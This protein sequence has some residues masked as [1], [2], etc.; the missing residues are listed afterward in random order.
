MPT[1]SNRPGK[2]RSLRAAAAR[3]LDRV[4]HKHRSLDQVLSAAGA[5]LR[6]EDAPL[7]R[8][9][10]TGAIRHFYSLQA[11]VTGALHRPLKDR[12]SVVFCLLLLG[13]YQL[14]HTR[15]PDHAAINET[16]SA[17]NEL[18]RP[19]ARALVNGVLRAV[20]RQPPTPSGDAQITFDHP[21]WLLERLQQDYPQRWQDIA[22]ANNTR[23]PLAL[24]VNLARVTRGD[25]LAL[26][27][28]QGHS[29][30][31]GTSAETILMTSPVARSV[32]P[33]YTDGWVSIQDEG[34]QL[35]APLLAPSAGQRVLDACAA[36]GG[37]ALHLAG[38]AECIDLTALEIDEQRLETLR[39]ES[40][41]LGMTLTL[42]A[43][44]ATQRDWWDGRPFDRILIDAPC[45]G[46][47]TLRRHPDIKLLKTEDDVRA[48]AQIQSKLL[49]NLWST[50][51]V[52]GCLLYCTCSVLNAEN[53]AVID[54]FLDREPTARVLPITT[55]WTAS[56]WCVAT[57]YGRQ[58]LPTSGGPD[59]FFFAIVEKPE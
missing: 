39:E 17:V 25:Y 16:V 26:L 55:N 28:Q 9:L 10:V 31:P 4:V 33:R 18:A 49:T 44:D 13:T 52:G 53:D 24:R 40:R 57:Q 3:D 54:D 41:R 6:P 59:G 29:A 36:P 56:N 2:P 5:K 35:A 51:E 37:K 14:R 7:H 48:F 42:Q 12:D 1:P 11:E 46:T 47:G 21:S 15:I 27:S 23:A 8:E 38:L 58:L 20:Q 19:W 50:L 32:L 22:I 30:A 34:A 43:G 45:S